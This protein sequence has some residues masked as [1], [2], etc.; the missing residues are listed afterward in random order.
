[1]LLKAGECQRHH[2]P[3]TPPGAGVLG[4]EFWPPFRVH[5]AGEGGAGARREREGMWR[6][7]RGRPLDVSAGM[8]WSS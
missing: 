7:R 8:E 6:G 2:D 4:T 5:S 3:P 1:M